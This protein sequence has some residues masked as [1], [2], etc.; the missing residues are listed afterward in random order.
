MKVTICGSMVFCD[1]MLNI[2]KE[3]EELGHE[4]KTPSFEIKDENGNM[5]PVK[6]YRSREKSESSD[7]NWIQDRR[8]EAMKNHFDKV[9]W[10]DAI[11]VLNYDKNNISN[12]IGAN[13][14]L[15]MGLATY[16]DKKIFLLNDVPE[17][18]YKEEI[19]VMKP[20]VINGNLDLVK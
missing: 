4:V 9:E 1:E 7:T 16:F 8:R 14:L 12:R 2:Q 5:I 19:L 18:E 17:I 20:I 11:M 15:E 13:T 6:E 10:S 3:L